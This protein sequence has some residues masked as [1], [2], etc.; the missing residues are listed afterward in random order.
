MEAGQQNMQLKEQLA[1]ELAKLKEADEVNSRLQEVLKK[2]Y[3][4]LE[5]MKIDLTEASNALSKAMDDI[6]AAEQKQKAT[7]A[8]LMTLKDS[9]R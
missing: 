9:V 4:E 2:K 7:E 6:V 5:V 3:A 1:A 8:K